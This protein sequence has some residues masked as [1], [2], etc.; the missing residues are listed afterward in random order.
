MPKTLQLSTKMVR[1][2]SSQ[3]HQ[4]CR[5]ARR[6]ESKDKVKSLMTKMVHKMLSLYSGSIWLLDITPIT[7]FK[8]LPF[9]MVHEIECFIDFSEGQCVGDK[10][11]HL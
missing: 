6:L 5:T 3:G 10:L 7:T 8:I 4:N 11:I 2:V 1:L 9:T